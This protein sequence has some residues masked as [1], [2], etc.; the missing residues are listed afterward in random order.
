ML[1]ALYGGAE[2]ISP[3][4]QAAL[5][6]LERP[7]TPLDTLVHTAFELNHK[8]KTET[9]LIGNFS[10]L[11]Y[12]P[13]VVF[14]PHTMA[15]DRAKEGDGDDELQSYMKTQNDEHIIL[16]TFGLGLIMTGGNQENGEGQGSGPAVLNPAVVTDEWTCDVTYEL[17]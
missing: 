7:F 10:T 2:V 3:Q 8:I 1:K 12:P 14:D 4:L 6:N 13:G 17:D 11:Y 9:V 16:S 15:V 5:S